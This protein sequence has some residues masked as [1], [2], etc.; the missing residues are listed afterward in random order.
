MKTVFSVLLALVVCAN[1]FTIVSCS[2]VAAKD[3]D[4]MFTLFVLSLIIMGGLAAGL[5]NS[6]KNTRAQVVELKRHVARLEARLDGI[7]QREQ[8]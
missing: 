5:L 3:G 7:T 2:I 4:G 1:W 8:D 6:L